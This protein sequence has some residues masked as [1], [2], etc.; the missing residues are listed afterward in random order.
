MADFYKK[1]EDHTLDYQGKK[2]FEKSFVVS[3]MNVMYD[4]IQ[5]L[6]KKSHEAEMLLD[7]IHSS[8]IIK[9]LSGKK[10][11]KHLEKYKNFNIKF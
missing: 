10:I 1:Y 5:A 3:K 7:T 8:W 11:K 9:L 4:N 2:Y 6:Q